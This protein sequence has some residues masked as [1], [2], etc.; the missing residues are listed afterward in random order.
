MAITL[1]GL[2]L[3][4]PTAS[5][6]G[7]GVLTIA[8]DPV[9]INTGAPQTWAGGTGFGTTTGLGYRISYSCSNADC[10]GSVI[11]LAPAPKDPTYDYYQHLTYQNWTAP[12]LGATIA[13]NAATGLTINLGN[14]A[15]GSVGSF[16]VNYDWSPLGWANSNT[17]QPAQFFPN[18]FPL[19]MSATAESSTISNTPTATAADVEWRSTIIDPGLSLSNPGTRNAGTNVSYDIIMH[20]GCL[21]IRETAPKGD[22]RWTCAKSYTVTHQIDP[23]AQFVSATNGGVYDPATHTVTWSAAPAPGLG[24]PAA[25]WYRPGSSS[26]YYPRTVTVNYPVAA[27]S[28]DGTDTDY[29]NF[30]EPVTT[31]VDLRMVYLGAGGMSDNSNVRTATT[32]QTHSISCERPFPK[33]IFNHKVSTFDGQARI[34]G[35]SPVVVQP[36]AELNRHN[37]EISV[38]NQANVPGVAVIEDDLDVEGTRVD[39]IVVYAPGSNVAWPA[40]TI[41]WTLDNGTTGT[42]TGSVTAPAGRWFTAMKVT[43]GSLPAANL[44]P[45]GTAQQAV[46]VRMFYAVTADAPVG[47]TRT[48]TASA[49]M[50]YPGTP[51]LADVVLTPR[52][53]GITYYE[54]FGRGQ[55]SKSSTNTGTG[56]LIVPPSTG[57]ATHYWSVVV[58][59]TG[60]V[61]A[62]GVIEDDDLDGRP[63]RVNYITHAAANYLT[64][65]P[66]TV[67]YTLNT[68]VTGTATIPFT[69]P[70]GTWITAVKVTTLPLQPVNVNTSQNSGASYYELRLAYPVTPSTPDGIWTNTARAKLTFPNMGVPDVVLPPATS[71]VSYGSA[72]LRPRIAAQFVGSPVVEGGGQAVP[73]RDVTYSLRGTSSLV[74]TGA[75][76]SPQYVFLAPVDWQVVDGSAGFAAGTVPPGAVFSYRTVTI[77]GVSR[78]AVVASWPPGTDFGG[79]ATWPTMTVA[80]Q[81]TFSAASGS[82]GTASA[83]AG[84]AGHNWTTSEAVYT[85]PVTDTADIDADGLTTEGFS[86]VNA[87]TVQVGAA[88]RM[89]V[90]KEICFPNASAPDGCEWVSEPGTLVGVHPSAT[91]I[92]YKVRLV[93]SGNTPL[94]NIVAYDVLPY[95]GDTGTSGTLASSPRNSTF[96]ELLSEITAANGL[97]LAFSDSTNPCRPQVYPGQPAGCANDWQTG[98]AQQADAQAIRATA[99]AALAPGNEISFQYKARVVPGTA[100][101]SVACNSV[102]AK[103]DQMGVAAEPLPVCA[104]TQQADLQLTVPE[105]LPLQID[106]VGTVPYTVTNNGPSAFAPAIVDVSVPAGM[107]VA[108]LEPA[109]W[110]CTVDGSTQTGPLT[111]SCRSVTPAGGPRLLAQGVPDPLGVPVVPTVIPTTPDHSVCL[112]GHAHGPVFDPDLSNN[113]A[114]SC[115]TVV[116]GKPQLVVAK[117]DGRNSVLRG[118]EYTYTVTITNGLV[119]EAIAD[120]VVTDT[121]PAGLEFVSASDAG[122][123]SGGVVTWTNVDLAAAGQPNAT[124]VDVRG[125]AGSSVTRTVTVRV[126]A[127]ATGAIENVVE[128]EVA[129]PADPDRTLTATDSDIDDLLLFSIDKSV[130]AAPE[131][132]YDGDELS[133]TVTVTNE[134]TAA[135]PGVTVRDVLTDL[136][137]DAG[138]VPGSGTVTVTGSATAPLAD[139]VAGELSWTGTLPANGSIVLRYR[140][141]VGPDGDGS[142]RNAAF[143]SANGTSCDPATGVANDGTPCATTTTRFAPLVAK[144]VDSLTHNDDGSWAI[145]YEIEV[146][147]RNP[148]AAVDYTLS[149]DLAFGAGIGVDSAIVT[150]GPAGVALEP[151]TGSG[152]VTGQ[153]TLPAGATHTYRVSVVADA[154]DLAGEPVAACTD[155]AAGGFG[156]VASL[157]L[158]S[159]RTTQTSTCVE[160]VEPSVTK[161]VTATSQNA[162]G[163]W[164]TGYTIEVSAPA[165]A[166][167]GGL[168]YTL[169]DSFDLPAGVTVREV[170]VTGPAGADLDPAFD[171]SSETALLTN[172]DRVGPGQTRTYTVTL[173][174]EVPAGAVTGADLLCGPAG[175]GGYANT[176][177]LLAGESSVAVD[178]ASAC[179]AIAAQPT[180]QLSKRV[181]GTAIDGATGRWTIG[182]DIAVTNPD[183]G[184]ATEYDL[185]DQLN[186]G[187]GIT[188][189]SAQVSSADA[190][191]SPSWD[192]DADPAVATG[193]LL[194]AGATHHY[195]VTVVADPPAVVD[196][197]NLAD[198]DCRIDAGETGTGLRNVAT[199]TSGALQAHAAACEAATDPTITKTVAGPPVQDPAT[200]LWQLEYL[201]SVTNRSTTTVPGGIPYTVN[202]SFGFPAGTVVRDIEVTGPGTLDPAFDGVA[203][204]T[205]ATGTIGAAVDDSTPTRHSYAVKVTFETPV[206]ATSCDAQQGPGGMRN[207]AELVVG[208]REIADVACADIPEAP[209]LALAKEVLSQ[210][211]RADGS[212][213]VQYRITVANTSSTIATRYDVQ[214]GFEL[215]DGIALA[216]PPVVSTRPTGVTLEAGWDGS[217][218]TTLAEQ[219]LLGAGATHR[220]TV[221][222]VVDAG[223]VRGNTGPGDCA[224]D[225]AE[226][227]T[228]FRNAAQVASGGTSYQAAACATAFD[229]G[230]TKRVDGAPVLNADGSWT[231]R[232]VIEVTN[233]SNQ[234]ELSYG[235][236][237]ALAFPAGTTIDAATATGRSGAPATSPTWNGVA[238]AVVVPD[239][240]RLAAGATHAFDVVVTATLPDGQESVADGWANQ[241][242]VASSTGGAVTS[243][244]AA[245]ADVDL[246]ELRVTKRVAAADVLRVGDTVRYSIEVENIG[247]GDYT[248]VRP[249]EVWDDLSG[250]LD[251]AT[252]GAVTASPA[253]GVIETPPGWL[254]WSGPL[255]A[256]ESVELEYEVTVTAA[257]DLSLDNVAF[258]PALRERPPATPQPCSGDAC[259]STSTPLAAFWLE[260]TASTGVIPTSGRVEYQLVYTNTGLVDVPDATFRDDLTGVLDDAALTGAITADSGEIERTAAGFVWT[261]PLAAGESVTVTYAVTVG[262]TPAGDA[263]LVNR[264]VADPEFASW[265]AADCTPSQEPCA[266]PSQT[267][268]TRTAVRALAF[269]KLADTAVTSF[270]RI[271]GYT[272]TITNVGSADFTA[273]D[274]ATVVDDLRGVLDDA[275]YNGDVTASVGTVTLDGPELTWT[276]PLAA[277]ESATF[278]FT[279]TVMGAGSGDG[280]LDNVIGLDGPSPSP[281]SLPRC[282]P[283][284]TDNAA[285]HCVASTTISGLP[286]TGSSA[287]SQLGL[288]LLLLVLGGGLVLLART[289]RTG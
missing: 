121:L 14:L 247:D 207:E 35:N 71:T 260:K 130:D 231:V 45:S 139:P 22:A 141:Q 132:V 108:D 263:V 63:V 135:F 111:L 210:Q 69:A 278:R 24:E 96:Q 159:G 61:P 175:S 51:G 282:A 119:G 131:G 254:H 1:T 112:P 113:D 186:F 109:G 73:G 228:G 160:P 286:V 136:L 76:F 42:S 275:R 199:L 285:S 68:G 129:D 180:P 62:V 265:P 167:A 27:F 11:R 218:S 216:E 252:L 103:A 184:Y 276:G 78:S 67:E 215:G 3:V 168:A 115:F 140:V 280:R 17:I 98:A 169:S 32:T 190:T 204:T 183:S 53:H 219:V 39:Q 117:T 188:V 46:T 102:A 137:D 163:S 161:T 75:S 238:D 246:P 15:A 90:V 213:A 9:D 104:T 40:A 41:E 211:Q 227:G 147:N 237:D 2:V 72:D 241:A 279:V 54:P 146:V 25:G 152:A 107:R 8:I 65:P 220:Y 259:S 153:V 223:S 284:P 92:T 6:A 49:R 36:A 114:D 101:D 196:A 208:G 57:S 258:A 164:S 253:G 250:V 256:G 262:T 177:R 12:F 234:V 105:R 97:N 59:N 127:D 110:S 209:A 116:V 251:D 166:P 203:V 187:D 34:S 222:A 200:G 272:V 240:A 217:A 126:A 266:G 157:E 99:A 192:G 74:P 158:S 226:T 181:T 20:S 255:A 170:T 58:R 281:G 144:S 26:K 242:T 81:P 79:N 95:L 134:G 29:C 235:L 31:K 33:A 193:V 155:G 225:G 205:L 60:N 202:D 43:S 82:M 48:N 197:G 52:A 23:R 30:I 198:L 156:N 249:A 239:G 83:W 91:D 201:V 268:E 189:L 86:T 178:Q 236:T 273:D 122:S 288:V 224:L 287:S 206:G 214:D 172:A 173:V 195:Q 118:D 120:V 257:G 261:G 94:T 37:W 179:T 4:A 55:L 277:G 133:Y 233:P 125:A 267:V 124:G 93:N 106:R 229:P 38:G 185:T 28:P 248:S 21:P 232:Y 274:P 212:W 18:G 191:F 145:G 230:V 194:P 243:S 123:F 19:K 269:T 100:V 87:A 271:V 221:T 162:D 13:G 64:T 66:A 143:T 44:L 85:N 171:G 70:A 88:A 10:D 77:S 174:T 289:G 244:A 283:N 5:A 142:L 148:D 84:E 165:S 176:V 50:T 128:A 264:A 56:G 154:G 47:Q 150:S 16:Q 7:D 151:W 80:A 89:S 245:A 182:Y 149:D 138:Y 270:G